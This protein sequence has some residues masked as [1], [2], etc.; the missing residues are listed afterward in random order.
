MVRMSGWKHNTRPHL[1]AHTNVS[2]KQHSKKFP[3]VYRFLVKYQRPYVRVNKMTKKKYTRVLLIVHRTRKKGGNQ[4]TPIPRRMTFSVTVYGLRPQQ[5]ET[6]SRQVS[7]VFIIIRPPICRPTCAARRKSFIILRSRKSPE[8][9]A[10]GKQL[11][12]IIRSKNE[13]K[14][15]T[16]T[17]TVEFNGPRQQRPTTAKK[18]AFS[19]PK[20]RR[21][22]P[23]TTSAYNNKERSTDN[24][25]D[26]QITA[27][28]T[29]DNNALRPTTTNNP[30]L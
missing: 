22:R 5:V 21:W 13:K 6:Y 28:A 27:I 23:S 17:T 30:P 2:R 7:I 14:R 29:H 19:M 8:E 9:G 26:A 20:L 24:L 18:D 15:P 4:G 10:E 25:L 3:G 1:N 16:A 11:F 12:P